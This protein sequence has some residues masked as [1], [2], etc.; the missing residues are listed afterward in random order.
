MERI[1]RSYEESYLGQLRKLIGNRTIISV[2][3]RA[4][5]L[6][7]QGRVLLVQRSDNGKWVMPAG[8]IELN[9][10]ILDCLKRE[11]WE[12][13]GLEVL[14][15]TP[16]ALYTEP[17]FAFTTAYGDHYHMFAVVFRVNHWQGALATATDETTHA[18]FF[19]LHELPDDVP[20]L[21]LETLKDFQQYERTKEF[22]LK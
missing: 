7:E 19:A 22:I 11:V 3:A 15:A 21:Y 14:E 13:T 10:S 17:R 20:A 2:G 16:I 9:E 18:Q 6:D 8:S 1:K 4:I 5:V 12:E